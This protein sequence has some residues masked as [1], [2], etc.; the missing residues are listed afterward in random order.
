MDFYFLL[1]QWEFF[2]SVSNVICVSNL[3]VFLWTTNKKTDSS[4]VSGTKETR[5]NINDFSIKERIGDG[6]FGEV[7]LAKEKVTNDI[8][9]IKKMPKSKFS[10]SKEERNILVISQSEWIPSLQ[11]AFQVSYTQLSFASHDIHC[12]SS[13]LSPPLFAV[14]IRIKQICT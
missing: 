8:Y 1:I 4:S 7:F 14:S 6:F 12:V 5:V 10:Q 2:C 13:S 9:A 11:Y 3:I